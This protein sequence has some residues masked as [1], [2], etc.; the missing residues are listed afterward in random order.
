MEESK[1]KQEQN[2]NSTNASSVQPT[3][4]SLNPS[5]GACALSVQNNSSSSNSGASATVR[6]TSELRSRENTVRTLSEH[7]KRISRANYQVD[8]TN[9]LI[10]ALTDIFN[11]P[12]YWGK[13][14]RYEAE[15]LLANKPE[16]SFLLRDSAQENYVF[17][18]SFRRYSRSLHARIEET[19]H[20]FSFD[21]HDPGVHASRDIKG[22]L[23][24]Y[25]DPLSCMFFEPM[26]LFPILRKKPFNL[27]ELSRTVICDN[28]T[29]NGITTLPIPKTLKSFLKEYHYKHKVASRELELQPSVLNFPPVSA[30]TA[31]EVSSSTYNNS[32]L[33]VQKEQ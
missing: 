20:K 26:L 33:T 8:Y 17:S 19:K 24:F 23:E 25:K 6:F 9:Y 14:D 32:H 21:C 18:V 16:G 11:C 28:T 4:S 27:Q 22:L 30:S 31:S 7:Q 12:F 1:E 10:P 2:Q 5:G 15:A 13:M 29:Y 3:G